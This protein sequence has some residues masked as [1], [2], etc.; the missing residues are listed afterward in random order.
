[1]RTA[2]RKTFEVFKLSSPNGKKW[3]KIEGRPTGRRERYYFKTEKEAKKGAADRN[4]QIVAFGSQVALPETERVMAAECIKLLSPYGKTLY[5]A[6]H[7]YRNHLERRASSISIGELCDRVSSEFQ[8]RLDNREISQRHFTSMKETL[9][10]FRTRFAETPA[11]LLEGL[12][13][14]SWLSSEELAVK[15]RNRHLGYVRNI[16]GIAQE[17]NLLDVDPLAKVSTFNDPHSKTAKVAILTSEQ[18]EKFLQVAD[19]DFVPF[20]ALNAFTGLRR[21]EVIRLDWSEIKLDRCLID[22]P[23]QKSKNRKRKLI[24]V[25]E[26]LIAWLKPHEQLAGSVMPRKKLQL[27]FE[28]AAKKAGILPWPQNA[29]RH[30]F[31]SYA[32]ASR[33][34]DWTAAQADHSMRMLRER[35]WE[36][37]TKDD[38]TKYWGIKPTP[39]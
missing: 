10:K 18:L 32:V 33:G 15:T 23:F 3:W 25:S 17:W 2:A 39:K 37:V 34:F 20:F 11:K 35:Y 21:E 30:S 24:E 31:C 26:N 29:L 9:K 4:N 12:E 22:L 7:F 14:K 1:M 28:S 13:V 8:R 6:V 36:V 27:A 16:L 38:A 19:P 5:D